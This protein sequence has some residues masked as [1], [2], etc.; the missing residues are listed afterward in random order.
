MRNDNPLIKQ[1]NEYYD[2][3]TKQCELTI[4]QY[5]KI[6]QEVEELH[7]QNSHLYL[8]T[9]RIHEPPL[10]NQSPR[11]TKNYSKLNSNDQFDPLPMTLEMIDFEYKYEDI[12]VPPKE[13]VTFRSSHTIPYY[14]N[15]QKCYTS[16]PFVPPLSRNDSETNHARP[17][18]NLSASP[19]LEKV[20]KKEMVRKLKMRNS[21]SE[22]ARISRHDQSIP[23]PHSIAKQNN[24]KHSSQPHYKK[25]LALIEHDETKR[26]IERSLYYRNIEFQKFGKNRFKKSSKFRSF[27]T[28]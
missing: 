4:N 21:I 8:K 11:H 25:V 14:Q 26:K 12:T 16:R 1:T 18:P 13:A 2:Y 3:I 7:E 20:R 22:S 9:I 5:M 10:K 28:I 27:E 15:L 19:R 6:N 17:I 24:N 23:L